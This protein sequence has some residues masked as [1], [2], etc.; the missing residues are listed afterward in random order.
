MPWIA[1]NRVCHQNVQVASLNVLITHTG[2]R[3][4]GE[5]SIGW[6]IIAI[7]CHIGSQRVWENDLA[8]L[9]DI[10]VDDERDRSGTCIEKLFYIFRAYRLNL[11]IMW[12]VFCGYWFL[13]NEQQAYAPYQLL[14]SR[15]FQLRSATI[16]LKQLCS[17]TLLVQHDSFVVPPRW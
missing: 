6:G 12:V 13:I 2:R 3:M 8:W 14:I 4:H 9:C 7:N 15:L 11:L 1:V 16:F 17:V 5:A 10:G